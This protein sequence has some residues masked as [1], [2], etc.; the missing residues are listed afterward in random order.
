M[1]NVDLL[2]IG[3]PFFCDFYHITM[4]QAWFQ[5]GAH[6]KQKT[7]EAYFR[8]CP[9]GGSYLVAAGLGEFLT[10]I[11]NWKF[12]NEHIEYLR[13]QIGDD[14]EPMFTEDFLSFLKE[15]KLKLNIKSV[16]EGEL[17]FPNEPVL[18]VSGPS[19]QVDMVEAAFLNIFNMQSLIATK[20][21]RIVRAAQ[22]DGVSRSVL[23]FGLRRAQELGG[24]SPTR[25]AYIGGAIA[26]SNV[27][28]GKYYDIPVKGTMAHSFVMAYESELESFKI[29]LKSAKGNATLLVDTYDT[30]Q[31]TK[32]AI[33]ASK[34]T[35]IDLKAIRIDS[36]D[37][38]YW[39]K[40][41]RN[42]LNE[43][44]FG[45]TKIV[46]SNDLDENV[47]ESLIA[48]QG[49]KAD[50][51]VAGTKL[52]TAYDTPALGGVFKTK[53]FEGKPKIKIADGKTTIPGS[54]NIIRLFHPDGKYRSDIIIRSEDDFVKEG[55]LVNDVYSFNLINNDESAAKFAKGS[56]A[57]SLLE[58]FV[59]EGRVLKDKQEI[60]VHK[61]RTRTME[62]LALLD[63]SHK[64]LV[65][66]HV[67][68]VGLEKG[69]ENLQRN[70][71][72]EY[73]KKRTSEGGLE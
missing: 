59:I 55:K 38:A 24:Y 32:N 70:M 53:S 45:H 28:A 66:P 18:S 57:K 30:R 5:N 27:S 62:N 67:Y 42:I 26:T 41:A 13:Q 19:W 31:G 10:W 48:I 58:D 71:V 68:T 22:I 39:S 35:G 15:Q 44:G 64:C 36:G 33:M 69:L 29:F 25:A 20:A 21:S 49:A 1:R 12:S 50:I 7:S 54:T 11:D 6:N 61:L 9:F 65:N 2:K 40:E 16:K 4:A 17:V 56:L 37:L 51:I 3:D 14:N 73:S 52:V 23:E 60:D 47:I 63:S 46:L 72:N 34:E 8:K 43:A